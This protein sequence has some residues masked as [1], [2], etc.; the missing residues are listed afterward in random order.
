MEESREMTFPFLIFTASLESHDTIYGFE[1]IL[2]YSKIP[3]ISPGP[4]IIIIIAKEPA[5]RRRK[6]GEVA[7]L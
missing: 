7:A 2:I 1:T 5:E 6:A 3:K 4:Y